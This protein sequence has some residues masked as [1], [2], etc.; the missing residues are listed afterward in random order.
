MRLSTWFL[1]AGVPAVVSCSSSPWHRDDAEPVD[2]AYLMDIS[3]GDRDD[4]AKL[5]ASE[6]EMQD[7][8]AFAERELEGEKA[9]KNVAKQ[10]LDVAQAEVDAAEARLE[11]ARNDDEAHDARERC[12][13]CKRH[14]AWAESQLGYHDARIEWARAK[15]D[16]AQERIDLATARTERRKAEAVKDIDDGQ[17]P[18]YNLNAYDEAIMAAELNV[19]LAEIETQARAD[20]AQAYRES[21]EALAS[22]I[23]EDRRASWRLTLTDKELGDD[24]IGRHNDVKDD[25]SK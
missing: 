16:L 25:D 17:T 14:V 6:A 13:D 7:Q 15:T 10:E 2:A 9:D 23:P 4:I 5:R 11:A 19:R 8:R 3:S 20:K 12:N 22:S 18:V 1:L 21:M 24:E